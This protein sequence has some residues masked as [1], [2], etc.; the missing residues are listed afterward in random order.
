MEN[1]HTPETTYLDLSKCSK[2]EIKYIFS[3][4]PEPILS[5]DYDIRG[6]YK[7]LLIT[8][9]FDNYCDKWYVDCAFDN[10]TEINFSEWIELMNED[11]EGNAQV[12]K[13]KVSDFILEKIDKAIENSR[14][15]QIKDIAHTEGVLIGLKICKELW[16]QGNISHENIQEEIYHY[17]Q[18]LNNFNINGN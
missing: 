2:K 12:E 16:A 1:K 6:R 17:Q 15:E 14:I 10:K 7:Y 5:D 4:L 18:E 13:S 11:S 3:L 9:D 8:D